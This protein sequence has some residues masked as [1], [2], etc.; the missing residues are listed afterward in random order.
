MSQFPSNR[1]LSAH[2]PQAITALE[3]YWRQIRGA[4]IL[5]VRSEV[6]PS[7]IDT[8]L[9]HAF[10]AERLAPGVTRMRACGRRLN[11]M[12]HV[13]GRGMPLSTFFT[14]GARSELVAEVELAFNGPALVEIHL[15]AELDAD[16]EIGR[17]LLLPLEGANGAVDRLMGAIVMH[18]P[19][20]RLA[21]RRDGYIRRE[22]LATV[23]R[24]ALSLDD[25]KEKG[26]QR[27]RPALR[28]VV[29]ND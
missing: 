1:I 8:A 27:L 5:P 9:P 11:N 26:P 14:L 2:R 18:T 24:P 6:D 23:A 3:R 4:R 19:A 21:I 20:R 15:A 22:I 25:M 29:S 10:I 7:Q 12:I 16:R 17:L 28:L 13:D